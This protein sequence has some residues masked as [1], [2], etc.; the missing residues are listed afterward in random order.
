MSPEWLR[1]QDF[2]SIFPKISREWGEEICGLWTGSLESQHEVRMTKL[3]VEYPA[4]FNN[5]LKIDCGVLTG[6]SRGLEELEKYIWYPCKR[7][8][9]FAHR[10]AARP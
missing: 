10:H 3:S 9:M 2:K 6:V 8:P 7:I 1:C 5:F 4:A